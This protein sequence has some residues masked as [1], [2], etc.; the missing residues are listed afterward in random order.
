MRRRLFVVAQVVLAIA[1]LGLAG[2]T[3]ARQWADMRALPVRID[4]TWY[5]MIA[6][7]LPPL[8]AYGTLIQLWRTILAAWG[9]PTPALPAAR[10]WFVS[11]LGRYVPGR[12][13]Q[14]GAMG[15]MLQRRGVPAA[16]SLGSALL[17][18]IISIVTGLAVVLAVGPN[19]FGAAGVTGPA[20]RAIAAAVAIAT[21]AILLVPPALPAIGH[22]VERLTA[23]SFAIPSLPTR[24]LAV[25]TAE[26]AVAWILLGLGF[27]L[28]AASL[29]GNATGASTTYI[30]V[31]VLSYLV[32]FL[33]LIAPGG[34]VVREAALVAGLTSAGVAT[35]A[36]ATVLAV[37]SRLWLTLL[38][39]TPG[40]CLL[41]RPAIRRSMKMTID[42]S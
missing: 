37:V 3:I 19:A 31:F 40:A 13:W 4:P 6:S 14:L 32:G 39:V 27:H 12:L 17:A 29:L 22:L 20:L 1:V 38:E 15:V 18:N 34:I 42:G 30:S 5:V 25:A 33:V 2:W 23:R 7:L 9:Y 41:V 8:L 35:L 10:I 11:S 26:A 21:I 28:L 24:T 16:V 36:E